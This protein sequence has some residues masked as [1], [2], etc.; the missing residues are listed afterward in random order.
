MTPVPK[1]EN[2]HSD[3]GVEVV[4]GPEHFNAKSPDIR[5]YSSQPFLVSGNNILIFKQGITDLA[6]EVI[7]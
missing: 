2:G 4:L 5:S 3:H 6:V 1:N 7:Q